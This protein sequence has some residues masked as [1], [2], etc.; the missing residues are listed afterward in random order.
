MTTKLAARAWRFLSADLLVSCVARRNQRATVGSW[1]IEVKTRT[2]S[3]TAPSS[4]FTLAIHNALS[5]ASKLI[6]AYHP[7]HTANICDTY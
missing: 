7:R 4:L 1:S 2:I 5:Q 3:L 6:K